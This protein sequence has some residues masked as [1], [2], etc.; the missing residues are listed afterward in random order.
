MYHFARLQPASHIASYT[1]YAIRYD[2]YTKA[3]ADYDWGVVFGDR[4]G[5]AMLVF[6]LFFY[7]TKG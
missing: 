5:D 3:G 6:V 4:N 2:A 1:V 7:R